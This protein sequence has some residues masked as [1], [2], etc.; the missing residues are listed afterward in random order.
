MIVQTECE[1]DT[2]EPH[3]VAVPARLLPVD[4]GTVGPSG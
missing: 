2:I 4:A 1:D 3:L